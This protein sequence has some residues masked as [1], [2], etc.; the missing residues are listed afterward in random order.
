MYYKDDNSYIPMT[1]TVKTYYVCRLI[2]KSNDGELMESQSD[3]GDGAKKMLNVIPCM[4]V[5]VA[6]IFPLVFVTIY[7]SN[8]KNSHV[9]KQLTDSKFCGSL[10]N[11]NCF[12]IL[13]TASNSY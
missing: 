11:E 9:F 2:T 3:K 4:L 6:G 5:K 8:D 1:Y 12:L 13:D 10:A 7:L